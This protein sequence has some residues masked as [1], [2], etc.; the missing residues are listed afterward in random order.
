M[1]VLKGGGA[2]YFRLVGGQDFSVLLGRSFGFPALFIKLVQDGYSGII[3]I[4]VW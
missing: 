4:E 1:G 3:E 2:R